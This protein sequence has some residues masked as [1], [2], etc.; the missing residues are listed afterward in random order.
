MALALAVAAEL[1]RDMKMEAADHN[2]TVEDASL[3]GNVIDS[4]KF[5]ECMTVMPS[6]LIGALESAIKRNPSTFLLGTA[7]DAAY[8]GVSASTPTI[9]EVR[10]GYGR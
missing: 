8:C 3:S 5:S 7:A 4:K 1:G 2:P 6:T 9:P 10:R